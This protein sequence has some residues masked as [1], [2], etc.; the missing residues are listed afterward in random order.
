M[1][2]SIA[3]GQT[4]VCF[5]L[6]E[7]S[8]ETCFFDDARANNGRWKVKQLRNSFSYF[9]RVTLTAITPLLFQYI[10]GKSFAKK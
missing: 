10:H 8:W 2:D 5:G 7:I 3:G 4:F 1:T 6:T 9:V